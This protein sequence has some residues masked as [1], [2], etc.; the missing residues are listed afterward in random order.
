MTTITYSTSNSAFASYLYKS[1]DN[2]NTN[3]TWPN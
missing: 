1:N 3:L 2:N